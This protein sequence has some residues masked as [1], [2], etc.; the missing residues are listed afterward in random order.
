MGRKASFN[1]KYNELKYRHLSPCQWRYL[2]E[3]A[4]AE[5]VNRK[6]SVVGLSGMAVQIIHESMRRDG[7]I[8]DG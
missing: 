6:G 3:R 2:K 5:T 7:Y 1:K 8:C 4:E